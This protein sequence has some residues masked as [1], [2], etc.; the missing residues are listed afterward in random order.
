MEALE[1]EQNHI[2]NRAAVVERKLRQLLETGTA[3]LSE[4][5]LFL[6]LLFIYL[7][8]FWP[9]EPQEINNNNNDNISN[10]NKVIVQMTKFWKERLQSF[11]RPYLTM[12]SMFSIFTTYTKLALGSWTSVI[13]ISE[14]NRRN[15]WLIDD[16]LWQAVTRWRK[17]G[18]S[19]NGLCWLTR[20]ML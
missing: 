12:T 19:R 18:W 7:L 20:K 4:I 9:I 11:S 6:L 16:S 1:A 17:R 14:G 3:Q 13:P 15:V 8:F 2:D 5:L 10:L